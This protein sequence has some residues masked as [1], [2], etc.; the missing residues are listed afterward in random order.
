MGTLLRGQ[1]SRGTGKGRAPS[2]KQ[3]TGG[4]LPAPQSG[5]I[6]QGRARWSRGVAA[7]TDTMPQMLPPSRSP[8]LKLSR[9]TQAGQL[10]GAPG[11]PLLPE[12][13]QNCGV[14]PT[15]QA[16]A[17]KP[18]PQRLHP[19]SPVLGSKNHS[20]TAWLPEGRAHAQKDVVSQT[21]ACIAQACWRHTE[22]R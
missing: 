16:T 19:S 6:P 2:Q 21:F 7:H 13:H 1:H 18:E 8:V 20:W 14:R 11:M 10:L 12:R 5:E 9:I 15:A 4:L 3:D 22:N 17:G